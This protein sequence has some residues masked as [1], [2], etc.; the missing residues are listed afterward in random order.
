[1]HVMQK[2]FSRDA[3]TI[4]TN[5]CPHQRWNIHLGGGFTAEEMVMK[6]SVQS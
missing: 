1:M 2:Q 6:A 5:I 3:E 4:L